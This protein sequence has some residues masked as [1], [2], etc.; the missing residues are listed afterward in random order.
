[1]RHVAD[2]DSAN[3]HLKFLTVRPL[4]RAAVVGR[5]D[6]RPRPRHPFYDLVAWATRPGSSRQLDRR[7]P[8]PIIFFR[9]FN[10]MSPMRGTFYRP[11]GRKNRTGP[12]SSSCPLGTPAQ[13][14]PAT[15]ASRRACQSF[16]ARSDADLFQTRQHRR[17]L[18]L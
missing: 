1:W 4:E 3:V 16:A 13:S 17:K 14:K 10:V 5:A 11:I 8:L 7:A 15:A 9:H 2:N 18:A 12:A 6:R